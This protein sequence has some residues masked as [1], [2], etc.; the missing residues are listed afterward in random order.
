MKIAIV[1]Y[2]LLRMRGGEKVVEALCELFPQADLFTHVADASQLSPSINKHT[3]KTTF[4]A[5]LPRAKKWYKHYLPFMPL[6]LEQLDL[7]DYDLVISTESGPAKGVITRP[8]ALHVCYCHTPMRYA[9]DMYHEYLNGQFFL[10]QWL[11]RPLMHYIRNWDFISAARVDHFIANSNYVAKR[12]EKFYRRN[13]TVINP[14]IDIEHFSVGENKGDYYLLLGQLVAYKRADI[15][16]DAFVESGKPL[17]VIGDGEMANELKQRASANIDFL[18]WQEGSKIA[19]YLRECRALLFPGVEDFGI[20]PLEA[21]ASGTPVIAYAEGGAL[22][23]VIDQST[24]L[25]FHQQTPQALNQA[26]EKFEA[27]AEQF[28]TSILRQHAESFSKQRFNKEISAFIQA[29]LTE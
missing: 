27:T 29:K 8:D 17:I 12:I 25:F 24:G 5:K 11:M 4:I 26:I 15:A 22:E 6:A 23:T 19:H 10:K 28:S 16:I 2:W 1:H 18:G 14:P 20:V 13:A 9:W 7:S 21:M 3:I